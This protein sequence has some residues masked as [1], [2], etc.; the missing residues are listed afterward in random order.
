[1][2]GLRVIS[3]VLTMCAILHTQ[4]THAQLKNN[5]R[6]GQSNSG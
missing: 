4:E 5:G 6:E 2:S 1:V 3:Y